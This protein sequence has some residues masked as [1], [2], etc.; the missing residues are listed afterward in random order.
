MNL[1]LNKKS[2]LITASELGDEARWEEI[3]DGFK[4]PFGRLKQ[5]EDV[6]S[7]STMLCFPEVT[8]LSGTV[9]DMDGGQRWT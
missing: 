3:L 4:F 8:Y 6:A 1:Q 9:V 5:P 2:V 7:L